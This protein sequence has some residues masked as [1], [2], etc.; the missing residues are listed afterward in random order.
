[1]ERVP[2]SVFAVKN[3]AELPR[4]LNGRGID[5][6]VILDT[7]GLV[8]SN[9]ALGPE[10]S[11][12]F[13]IGQ[14]VRTTPDWVTHFAPAAGLDAQ[15][16]QSST[17]QG[18]IAAEISGAL[19]IMTFGHAWRRVRAPKVVPNFGLRCVL[20]MCGESD[21]R[22]LKHDRISHDYVQT[23]VQSPEQAN[24]YRFGF[25]LEQD[26]L[27]GV[28]ASVDERLGFGPSVTGGDS[29]KFSFDPAATPLPE[30]LQRVIKAFGSEK[31]KRDFSWIDD[32]VS[33]S[34]AAAIA[35]LN[36]ELA[37]IMNSGGAG[38]TL[39][40]PDFEGWDEYDK[41]VF[42]RF[43]RKP[44]YSTLSLASWLHYARGNSLV[45]ITQDILEKQK[46]SA[47]HSRDPDIRRSWSA[48]ECLHGVI[49]TA[50]GRFLTHGGEWY[51]L[52]EGFLDRIDSQLKTLIDVAPIPLL[53]ASKASESEDKYN[54][55]TARAS[56]RK[57]KLLDKKL[58]MHG[59]GQS[60]VE[61]CDLF[62]DTLQ[63]ICVKR[64]SSSA[65]MSHLCQQSLVSGRLAR[66]DND[67]FKKVERKLKGYHRAAWLKTRGSGAQATFV[68]VLMFG[69]PLTNLPLFSRI[70]LLDTAKKLLSLG[71][72]VSYVYV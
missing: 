40:L 37:N 11:G 39:C 47:V 50:D 72:K 57:L 4:A 69:V 27:K 43:R 53:P 17:V 24:I 71:Y 19:V 63:F 3:P 42:G 20:N 26:L 31:Y 25:D 13:W 55:R 58:V 36:K 61:I 45:P 66:S 68:L 62:S 70:T 8:E 67:Y 32:I 9:I 41:F 28:R 44:V 30:L 51:R 46:I 59:G 22:A 14:G 56:G 18:A 2:I 48:L 34:D 64:W 60:K 38:L 52:S 1:M 35:S 29:F 21:L 16:F 6:S 12:V 10:V 7:V 54:K 49:D 65:G 5:F 15:D 23:L 33:I